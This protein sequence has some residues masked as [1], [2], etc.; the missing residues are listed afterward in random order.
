MPSTE[1]RSVPVHGGVPTYF[2]ALCYTASS[3]GTSGYAEAGYAMASAVKADIP[4]NVE[5]D[6]W[7]ENYVP[8][9][10]ALVAERDDVAVLNWLVCHFPRW[11]AHV[12]KRRRQSFLA[13]IYRC[14]DEM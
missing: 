14:A 1:S 10:E 11:M 7:L 4:G 12:P 6:E 13:G 5:D 2:R 8:C 9:F 3:G